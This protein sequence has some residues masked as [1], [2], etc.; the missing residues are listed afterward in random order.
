LRW[1][2]AAILLRSV[3][4][5][6]AL[7]IVLDLVWLDDLHKKHAFTETVYADKPWSERSQLMPDE[8]IAQTAA[9][10]RGYFASQPG[11]HRLLVGADSKYVFLKL[12]YELL[13]LDAA[14][15]QEVANFTWPPG[16]VFVLLYNDAPWHYDETLGAIVDAAGHRIGE[17]EDEVFDGGF[18]HPARIES[19]FEKGDVRLYVRR[20]A[21]APSP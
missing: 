6:G 4:A 15:L 16:E 2:R 12:I 18:A 17:A 20:D 3:A 7:W 13:P 5:I 8:D 14:P 21:E 10:V 19:V 11:A 1:S 9:R